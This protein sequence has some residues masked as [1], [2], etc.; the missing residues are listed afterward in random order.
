[1]LP[2]FV[3]TVVAF[4]FAAF[5]VLVRLRRARQRALAR[6]LRA[7]HVETGP[8]A[9]GTIRG[10]DF[11]IDLTKAGKT[12]VTH[13]RVTA[14]SAPGEYHLRRGFFGPALDWAHVRV[15]A[16]VRQRVFLWEVALPGGA[17]PDRAGRAALVDWMSPDV[18]SSEY[19]AALAAARIH[20]IVVAH[21]FVATRFNGVVQAPER[22]RR[23]LAALRGLARDD[24]QRRQAA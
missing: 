17:E 5:A 13:V 10:T 9:P 7:R 19:A 1:M 2:L 16:E 14:P 3:G 23:T 12:Y 6:E 22:M 4:P 21:G 24:A 18:A 20:E 15:P 8:F 11:E